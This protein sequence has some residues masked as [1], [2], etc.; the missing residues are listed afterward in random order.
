MFKLVAFLFLAANPS[1]P[2]G[3]M[4][5]NQAVFP[6]EEVCAAFVETDV[7]KAAVGSIQTMAQGRS[8]AVKFA[9]VK[10]EDNTI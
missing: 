4:T 1:E 2:I 6:S 5:Y 9:C 3:Q 8:L 10:A 7:G